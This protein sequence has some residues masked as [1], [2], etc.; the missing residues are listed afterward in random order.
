[1]QPIINYTVEYFFSIEI[2]IRNNCIIY[3]IIIFIFFICVNFD[4]VMH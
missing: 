4:T 2:K 1:M 3:G